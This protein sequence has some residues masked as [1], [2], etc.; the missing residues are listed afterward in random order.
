MAVL[1]EA[2]RRL[3]SLGVKPT[4]LVDY[5]VANNPA[6]A[7]ILHSFIAD[8]EA[9]VGAQLHPWV[10]P[11]FTETISNANS[12][13]GNLPPG[14]EQAKLTNLTNKIREMVGIQPTIYRAGRYGVGPG[15]AKLL[16]ELGY[17]LDVSTRPLFDYSSEG[18]PDFSSFP[19][20]PWWVDANRR[21]LEMP[22]SAIYAGYW[23]RRG[24]SL[25]PATAGLPL[26]RGALAKSGLL[27]RVALTPEGMPLKDVL[28]AIDIML[29]QP[30]GVFSLSFHS[31]S[32]RPGNTPYVRDQAELRSFW[33]WWHK[34]LDRF[35]R[36]GVQPACA[37][38]FIDAARSAAQLPA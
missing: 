9:V 5:P 28:Q 35:A 33:N 2:H 8:D 20:W 6:A 12:F 4:Y 19:A 3:S 23:R 10:N 30:I 32:L 26:L 13:A 25:F 7:A 11:P 29:D 15:T 34:V 31:P 38:Q 17:E 24:G 37:Y 21:L 22:L 18:G 16:I 36:A 1:P 27:Q 14:V